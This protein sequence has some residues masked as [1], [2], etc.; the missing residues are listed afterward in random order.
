MDKILI[1]AL[2]CMAHVGVPEA[3]RRRKQKL[4]LDLELQLD[5]KAAGRQDRVE[6]TLDYAAV[7]VEVQQI[8]R[9]KSF[10]LVE[11]LAEQIAQR[12][13]KKF[14]PDF[15][16]VRVRKFS[17]PGTRSVGVEIIR[18]TSQMKSGFPR[19]GLR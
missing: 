17:V 7:A 8:V 6:A 11:A 18:G 15:V 9:Q 13:L 12:I 1:K 4:L 10:R 5:L 19:T 3:E 2:R 14:K 16:R